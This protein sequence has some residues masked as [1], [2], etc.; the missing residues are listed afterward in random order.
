MPRRPSTSPRIYPRKGIDYARVYLD[1]KPVERKLGPSGSEESRQAY[2]RFCAEL[3]ASGGRLPSRQTVADPTILTVAEAV[4]RWLTHASE[5]YAGRSREHEQHVVASRPL[6]AIWGTMPVTAFDAAALEHLQLQMASG[7]WMSEAQKEAARKRGDPIGWCRNVINRNCVRIKTA[8]RWM[9][10]KKLVPPGSW[11]TLQTVPGLRKNDPRVRHSPR[12]RA[13]SRED[14]DRVLKLLH[15][16]VRSMLLL[17]W[18]TGA[19]P[20]EIRPMRA[21]DIDRSSEVWLYIPGRHKGDWREGADDRVVP[22][23][24]EARSLIAFWLE[25]VGEGGPEAYL[26]K[27]TRGSATHYSDVAY[28]RAVGRAADRAGVDLTH[29]HTRHA[30]K[31]RITQQYGLDAARAVLGQ[32]S[33]TT[34]NGYDHQADVELATRVAREMG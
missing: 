4:C 19:R 2:L 34:T 7:S 23:G 5:F 24:A 29:Y 25:R 13:C 14:L 9:E 22:L 3:S 6:L 8:W 28:S 32:K 21:G 31:R 10:R 30:A 16:P 17:G 1:G 26:F 20:G 27:P 12:R 18:L 15:E 33:L 11:G